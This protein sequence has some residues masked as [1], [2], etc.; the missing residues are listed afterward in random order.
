MGGWFEYKF[1]IALMAVV[2]FKLLYNQFRVHRIAV[3]PFGL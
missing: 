3:N 1:P 2:S